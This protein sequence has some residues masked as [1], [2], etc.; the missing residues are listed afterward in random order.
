MCSI[1]ELWLL[2]AAL[3]WQGGHIGTGSWRLHARIFGRRSVA[4]FRFSGRKP[5]GMPELLEPP[6][7]RGCGDSNHQYSSEPSYFAS[8]SLAN[9]TEGFFQYSLNV[10]VEWT[11][12]L[13]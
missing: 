5:A 1:P 13:M 7:R 4:E 10:M 3:A 11:S 8:F 6:P 2:E 9:L 12:K